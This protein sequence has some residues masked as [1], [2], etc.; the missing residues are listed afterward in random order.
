MNKVLESFLVL[1]LVVLTLLVWTSPIGDMPFGDVDS[2]GHF[3][4]GDYYYQSDRPYY[5]L[6]NIIYV[7]ISKTLTNLWY[8]PQFHLNA[9]MFQIIGG[10]RII[11]AYLF[12][13]FACSLAVITTY[14]LMRKLFGIF[15]ALLA[16]L[17]L[18]FSKRDYLA[19]LWGLWPERISY[20]LLPMVMYT[21]Y[22]YTNSY[23]K[24]KDNNAYLFLTLLLMA[25][26]YLM[27]P[28]GLFHSLV[29]LGIYTIFLVIKS[30]RFPV[31]IRNSILPV[32]LFILLVAPFS[33][34]TIR[35]VTQVMPQQSGDSLRIQ[36]PSRLF[37]WY[38]PDIP[39]TPW[40]G[41]YGVMYGWWTFPFL[42]LGIVYLL[43]KRDR[44]SL[45]MLSF[46]IGLYLL[47]HLDVIGYSNRV[48]RSL[49]AESHIFY[50]LIALGMY[51]AATALRVSRKYQ[52]VLKYS[53][54]V[55][56][57]LVIAFMH[58]KKE[59]PNISQAYAGYLRI[60]QPQYDAAVWMKDNVPEDAKVRLVGTAIY[61]KKKWIPVLSHR[62]VLFG[63][64]NDLISDIPGANET[65]YV[66]FDLSDFVTLDNQDA[67]GYLNYWGSQNLQGASQIYN[68][69]NV[70]IY[71][72][73]TNNANN[74]DPQ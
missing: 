11:P 8:P 29:V 18:A 59:Y 1:A 24:K 69:N 5:T 3:L 34:T 6:P 4:L 28:Q 22:R 73:D 9:A 50:P 19:Y 33:Y 46:L 13:A 63:G 21:Y 42:M 60:T 58:A 54:L 57:I 49:N 23:L 37:Q 74:T 25:C 2:S 36:N 64:H 56:F 38:P 14:F 51:F 67:I 20:A 47:M 15:P 27:H 39:Y 40:L 66:F 55:L 45:L 72:L 16:G 70:R 68:R 7:F 61:Y 48:H 17:F 44:K 52:P 35:Y 62:E 32:I 30:R 71:R 12:Y 65:E 10:S 43:I 53:L 31:S 26:Q 41:D